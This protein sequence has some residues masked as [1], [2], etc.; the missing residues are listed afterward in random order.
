RPLDFG[1]WA[2]HKLEAMTGYTLS[3]GHAV[4]I[5]MA[6]DLT[7]GNLM[8]W[9][10]DEELERVLT[11]LNRLGFALY[12]PMMSNSDALLTGLDEFREH[13]G[14]ERTVP[15]IRRSGQTF[16]VHEIQRETMLAAIRERAAAATR[17]RRTSIES[18]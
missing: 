9:F 14:G 17:P 8:G 1:H 13:R 10:S 12:H 3:H 18:V 5:G 15:M 6:L 7:Y 2:A 4:A 11:C 16:E